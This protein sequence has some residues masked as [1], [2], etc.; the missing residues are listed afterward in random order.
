M[1]QATSGKRKGGRKALWAAVALV[2]I[3]AAGAVGYKI[4]LEKTINA[5]LERRGGKAASVTA[6]FLGNIKLTDVVLPLKDGADITIGSIEGR[7]KVLF[8]SGMLDAK[9]VKTEIA[10]FKIALPSVRIDDANFDI[11]MLRDTFGNGELTLAERVGRFSA[12]R[13]SVPEINIVQILNDKEQKTSYKDVTLEDIVNGHVARYTSS[14]ATFDLDLSLPDENGTINEE[15]MAGTIGTSEGKDIDGVFIARLYTE[16]AGPNDTEAQPVYGP[17]SAKNIVVKATK[18]SFSYDEVR[19]N[20]ITMR[21]PAQPF[22][23]ILRKLD[24]AQKIDSLP[25]EEQKEFFA[26][27][28]GL[29]DTIGKGDVELLGMKIQPS[30]P[31]KGEGAIE[32]MAMSFDNKTFDMSL[33]GFSA[34]NGTDYI[35]L[36]E[37][38]L[39]G[40]NWGPSAEAVK[41]FVGLS[42]EEME[43]FP[44]T[45]MLPEF[46]TIVLKG[47][48]ADL[49]YDNNAFDDID[50]EDEDGNP[51]PKPDGLPH[52]L[53]FGLK[54]YEI[55]LNKP[56]NGIPTDIR[57]TYE[58]MS[59]PVPQDSNEEMY[60][61]LRALGYDRIT[62]SSNLEVNWDEASQS[63]VIKDLSLSGKDMGKVTMSGL[64]GGF[65]KEFF[66]G[67]KVLTQVALLGL[68]AREVNLKIENQGLAEKG[69][70]FYADENN[71]SVEEARSTLTLIASAVLQELAADQPKLEAVISALNAFIAKPNTFEMSVK[72]KSERGIGALEMVAISQDP[73]SILDKIEIE[74]KAD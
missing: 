60:K 25:P 58:D 23:E 73:F 27:L 34:G 63:L 42:E 6:D 36:D 67:D 35:K 9:D 48:D 45:T 14:G 72:S 19:S 74:A 10:Q 51:V 64:M 37:F 5:Q 47:I 28:I 44:F 30:D 55:G 1:K 12:K 4:T 40:F 8:L 38:S 26:N 3:A 7:P 70:Q 32:K 41:K 66:S 24:A 13:M 11:G 15:R 69:L 22:T 31:E 54:S 52:R 57:V 65:T 17:F 56:L 20:G 16:A 39:K 59:L 21:L 71:M 61:Q 62:I 49:P 50:I 33:D 43:S 46:G 53:K 68:K 18:S 29:F 2:A